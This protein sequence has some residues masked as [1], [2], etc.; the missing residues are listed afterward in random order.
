MGRYVCLVQQ[1]LN[2]FWAFLENLAFQNSLTRPSVMLTSHSQLCWLCL[3][4]GALG[5]LCFDSPNLSSL[6]ETELTQPAFSFPLRSKEQW[7]AYTPL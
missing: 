3:R 1:N 7:R 4:Q 2:C 6:S 5:Y